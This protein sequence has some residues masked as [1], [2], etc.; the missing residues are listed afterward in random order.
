MCL[1]ESDGESEEISSEDTHARVQRKA[2]ERRERRARK[3]DKDRIEF[4]KARDR[5]AP[6]ETL[7]QE[8]KSVESILFCGAILKEEMGKCFLRNREKTMVLCYCIMQLLLIFCQRHPDILRDW[9]HS[10]LRHHEYLDEV[11][12]KIKSTDDVKLLKVIRELAGYTISFRSFDSPGPWVSAQVYDVMLSRYGAEDQETL[13]A[14]KYLAESCVYDGCGSRFREVYPWSQ[15][16]EWI[17]QHAIQIRRDLGADRPHALNTNMP[18]LGPYLRRAAFLKQKTSF[19][20]LLMDAY[21]RYEK[22]TP[23]VIHS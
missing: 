19:E 1:F 20:R 2:D 7:R 6:A 13:L 8:G 9:S 16:E 21:Q 15:R 14:L 5:L 22:R 4:Q 23:N 17:Y 18:W 11:V 12:R 10:T 3:A